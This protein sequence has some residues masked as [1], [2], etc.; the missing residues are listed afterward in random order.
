L[1]ASRG[2]YGRGMLQRLGALVLALG[3]AQFAFAQA[4]ADGAISLPEPAARA[5]PSAPAPLH[6]AQVNANVADATGDDEESMPPPLDPLE[7]VNRVVLELN[8]HLDDWVVRP[9]ARGYQAVL[10]APVRTAVGNVF[11]NLAD[12]WTGANNLLQGKPHDAAVDASRFLMNSSFGLGGLFDIA[13]DFGLQKHKEDFGQTLGRWGV[14]GGPYLVLPLFGP[15]NLRDVVGV[16]GADWKANPFRLL[17]DPG[18]RNAITIT[19]LA[20]GRARLLSADRML[21]AISIDRYLFVRD[22]YLQRRQSQI[23]DG[24]SPPRR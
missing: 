13:S 8:Q 9:I 23:W 21:D 18:A 22:A 12:A 14:P 4:S 24:E 19:R 3:V 11:G 16:V 6:W 5:A 20:D 1:N 15:S 17:P 2:G 10:P 7:P